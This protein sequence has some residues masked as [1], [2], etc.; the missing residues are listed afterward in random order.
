MG[1]NPFLEKPLKPVKLLSVKPLPARPPQVEPL[2][3]RPHLVEPLPDKPF[4]IK[5]LRTA[6]STTNDFY[7][8]RILSH[9]DSVRKPCKSSGCSSYGQANCN[10]FCPEC[11]HIRKK[12][13]MA[14]ESI[15]E[16]MR[17]AQ[18]Q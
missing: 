14:R 10:W 9:Y 7:N 12:A 8:P 17:A 18:M 13:A 3:G 5:P 15:L 11:F 6:E 4:P 2:L 1:T 16:G